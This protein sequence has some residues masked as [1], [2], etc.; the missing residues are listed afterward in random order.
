MARH[1]HELPKAVAAVEFVRHRSL[2]AHDL[3]LVGI[4]R[5][6]PKVASLD[7]SPETL[8]ASPAPTTPELSPHY[9]RALGHLAGQYWYDAEQSLSLLNGRVQAFLPRLDPAVQGFFLQGV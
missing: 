5:S 8:A 6:W 3:T 2:A 7:A 9:W 4:Y 1:H